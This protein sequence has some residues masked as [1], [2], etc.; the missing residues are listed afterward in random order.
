MNMNWANCVRSELVL[1]LILLIVAVHCKPVRPNTKEKEK[2]E[3]EWKKEEDPS[4]VKY[5]KQ[6]IEILEEDESF[7]K[8]LENVTEADI[9]SGK[10]A[11]HIDFADHHVRTKLDELKRKEI[12]Y[13]RQLLRK[14]QDL[15]NGIHREYWNP[16]NDRE[17][18]N[19]FEVED[20]KR[21]LSK[22]RRRKYILIQLEIK[23][24][25]WQLVGYRDIVVNDGTDAIYCTVVWDC[26][27]KYAFAC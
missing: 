13:Q 21:L 4:Y 1:V 10:I 3:E 27:I 17:N 24:Y 25:P 26:K 19:S 23:T 18:P 14:Q 8:K 9:R 6:V 2:N 11:D 20:L 12:E 15:R 22:V 7:S 5:L 16:L